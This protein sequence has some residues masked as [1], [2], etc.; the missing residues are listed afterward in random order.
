[1]DLDPLNTLQHTKIGMVIIIIPEER[2]VIALV[3][4]KQLVMFP[5]I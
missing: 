1:V 5:I 4:N 2:D 3:G